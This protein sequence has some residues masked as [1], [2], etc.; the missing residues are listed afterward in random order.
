MTVPASTKPKPSA[1]AASQTSACLSNPA[2]RPIGFGNARV[3]TLV[4][5]IGSSGR[6]GIVRAKP[7]L[8]AHMLT[9][10][11]RSGSRK[12]SA[13]RASLKRRSAILRFVQ[14]RR[15]DFFNRSG[16]CEQPAVSAMLADQHQP[17]RRV[18]ATMTGYRDRAA[19]EQVGYHGVAKHQQVDSAKLLL[20]FE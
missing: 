20:G 6:R 14:L 5:R 16:D 3:Q 10:W 17:D 4:A 11:A 8:S 15:H 12:N 7:N 9:P 13:G 18:A 2:A 1:S 19:I